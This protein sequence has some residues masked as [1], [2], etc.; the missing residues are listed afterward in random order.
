[1]ENKI[2]KK[3]RYLIPHYFRKIG[4][5]IT[6]AAIIIPVI[7]KLMGINIIHSKKEILKLISIDLFMLGLFFVAFSRDK[8]EDELTIIIR[9]RAMSA[10]FCFGIVFAIIYPTTYLVFGD[11]IEYIEGNKL[12]IIMLFNYLINYYSLK[13]NR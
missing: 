11:P 8:V 2:I 6:I 3:Q 9:L 4:L 1:M 5:I 7:V 10:T 12:I 13:R